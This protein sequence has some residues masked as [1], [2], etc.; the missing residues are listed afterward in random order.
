MKK[1]GRGAYLIALIL[2]LILMSCAPNLSNPADNTA[3][4]QDDQPLLFDPNNLPKA[5]QLFPP[6]PNPFPSTTNIRFDL[7]KE[8]VIN[9]RVQNPVG[10]VIKIL[11]SERLPAGAFITQW[12]ATNSANEQVKNGLYFITLE[13]GNFVQSQLVKLER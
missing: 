6:Y 13:V 8:S 10:D 12:N 11:Q 7:P 9:L 2:L 1:F 3:P 5:Y 4:N